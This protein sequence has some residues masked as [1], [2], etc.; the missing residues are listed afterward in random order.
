[1]KKLLTSSSPTIPPFLPTHKKSQ[2]TGT[3]RAAAVVRWLPYL[4]E[5]QFQW[6]LTETKIEISKNK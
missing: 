4:T 3:A 2:R 6:K 1:M 5:R